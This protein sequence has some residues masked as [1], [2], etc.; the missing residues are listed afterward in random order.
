MLPT[1]VDAGG[2][3]VL[4]YPDGRSSRSRCLHC[5]YTLLM[6]TEPFICKLLMQTASANCFCKLLLQTASAKCA[7]S[8]RRQHAHQPSTTGHLVLDAMMLPCAQH[9]DDLCP[10]LCHP[11]IW[12]H[13]CWPRRCDVMRLQS[14]RTY[15]V[16]TPYDVITAGPG[17]ATLIFSKCSHGWNWSE[18]QTEQGTVRSGSFCIAH[19]GTF[20]R[21]SVRK[22]LAV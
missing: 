22:L 16:I 20:M 14:N 18:L 4:S 5:F 10:T 17:V 12:P 13:H 2:T 15:D 6:P 3:L 9:Y 8:L 7:V 1:G 11:V 21:M 19:C